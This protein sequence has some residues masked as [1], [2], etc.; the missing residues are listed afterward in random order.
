MEKFMTKTEAQN[1]IIKLR[2]EI[3]KHRYNYHV[4]DKET[5]S[6]AA[7]DS[8][9][10]ELF[11]LE[12]SYPDL[13]TPD[14]P[15]QRV[16]GAPLDKFVK[17]AHSQRMISLFDAFSEQ[18]M[19][20]WETRVFNYATSQG[21]V[22]GDLEYYCELKLDGLAINLRYE[23]GLLVQAATRGD[24]KVGEDVTQNIKTMESIPL[25][26]DLKLLQGV[27][28]GPVFEVRGEAI[29]E[30]STLEKLNKKYAKQG[31]PPLANTRNAA[32]GS[33]R[34]LDSSV[35][36]QRR[37]EFFEYDLPTLNNAA[38]ITRRDVADKLAGKL[39]FKTV[40]HNQSELFQRVTL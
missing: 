7:L 8:L 15:T 19:R 17:V 24:G 4:L 26:L 40:H 38:L 30:K 32:A 34:Q 12:Q 6:E 9:K 31:K 23:N 3:D 29:M 10:I 33:I 18:D 11:R 21:I 2:Q 1:R 20:D 27:V 28:S 37:L 25:A 35:M 22:L 14:S 13:V 16:G 5:M 39:G 36:A